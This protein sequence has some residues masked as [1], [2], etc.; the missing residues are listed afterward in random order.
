MARYLVRNRHS[1]CFRYRIPAD[2]QSIIGRKEIRYSLRTGRIGVAKVMAQELA[3]KI[4]RLV[5]ELRRK[6]R[7][8]MDKIQINR[9]IAGWI[10]DTLAEEEATRTLTERPLNEDFLDERYEA[11]DSVQTLHREALGKLQHVQAMEHRVDLILKEHGIEI[12]KDSEAYRELCRGMLK[13]SIKVLEVEKERTFGRYDSTDEEV[14]EEICGL[15]SREVT[16]EALR[17]QSLLV[18]LKPPTMKPSITLRGLIDEYQ[19]ERVKAGR[20]TDSTVRNYT[21]YFNAL[22]R[23]L[24]EDTPVRTICRQQMLNFKKLLESLPAGFGRLKEYQNLNN[25]DL[26]PVNPETSLL[27][28][29]TVRSYLLTAEAVFRHGVRLGY[30]DLNPAEGLKP[31]KKKK[32]RD[33]REVFS[34]EDLTLIFRYPDVATMKPFQFWLPI[35]GL[36]TGCRL[37]ELCQ[38]YTED[39]YQVDGVWV[40]D[41]NDNK[42]KK[43]KNE[44]SA[45]LV[46]LHPVLLQYNLDFPGFVQKP[47][48]GRKRV[49]QELK[50]QSGSYGHYASRWFGSYRKKVIGID[51]PKKVFH[52]FRHTMTDHLY[53]NMVPE[54]VIEELTGRA[55]KTQTSRRYAKGYRVKD[56][57]E[58]M[59]E[60]LNYQLDLSH[61]KDGRWTGKD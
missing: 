17:R 44:S 29:T 57:F 20:W 37:E 52:S 45:R 23:Y 35:L 21:P 18:N 60:K 9:L 19:D 16:G 24:G 25:E 22:T 59:A 41:I 56:L 13:A 54:S 40:L 26:P 2:L 6:E 27:D 39:V 4:R 8:H 50:K 49:F 34:E 7:V 32:A 36:Y 14:V 33:Q 31:P 48:D 43:I 15:S 51:S 61:L 55:G 10:R 30:M 53:K 3:L 28:M 5:R 42:D 11:L 1:Y 46:P 58:V 38:L 12:D 47:A